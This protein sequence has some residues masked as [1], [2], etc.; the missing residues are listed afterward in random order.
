MLYTLVATIF[1]YAPIQMLTVF[2]RL[3]TTLYH[4]ITLHDQCGLTSVIFIRLEA[5]LLKGKTSPC[6]RD[7]VL[8]SFF[9]SS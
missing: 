7:R 2:L 6:D 3:C 1:T 4:I 5:T 8:F 9:M